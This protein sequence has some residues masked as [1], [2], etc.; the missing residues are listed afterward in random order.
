[1]LEAGPAWTR[2]TGPRS[3][4]GRPQPLPRSS[5]RSTED[6][7]RCIGFLFRAADDNQASDAV[8]GDR[9]MADQLG[10]GRDQA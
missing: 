9:R 8:E 3:F 10:R 7:G 4:P 5:N 2:G 6:T 1:M